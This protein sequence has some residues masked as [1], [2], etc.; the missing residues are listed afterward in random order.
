MKAIA[1]MAKN[2]VIGYQGKIPWQLP[3]DLRFFKE[4][5]WGKIVIMG[6]K[7]YES[8]GH[9]LPGRKN[10]VLSRERGKCLPGV[11]CVFDPREAIRLCKES[12]AFVIGGES[13]YRVLLPWCNEIIMTHVMTSPKGDAFFPAFEEQFAP[14]IPIR[15]TPQMK[16]LL[17]LRRA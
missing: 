3:E 1:A 15:E 10:I 9:P 8:I 4:T 13:V 14:G 2:R 12:E 5:T 16:I 17:Y 11:F 7:T 6:R